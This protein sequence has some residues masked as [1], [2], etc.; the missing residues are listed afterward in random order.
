M[1][2]LGGY[3]SSKAKWFTTP[4][5]FPFWNFVKTFVF[6]RNNPEIKIKSKSNVTQN[7][8]SVAFF[9]T[10]EQVLTGEELPFELCLRLVHNI[11]S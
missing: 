9:Q 2:F 11:Q 8:I 5:S 1:S 4:L 6:I 3:F 7:I 10:T